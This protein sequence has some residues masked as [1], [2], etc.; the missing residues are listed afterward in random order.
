MTDLYDTKYY[1]RTADSANYNSDGAGI[2][3]AIVTLFKPE[4]VIDAGCGSGRI[5]FNL[6]ELGCKRVHGIEYS[7]AAFEFMN[8]S[9]KDYCHQ[10]DM[11]DKS[12]EVD[13]K[14]DVAICT[15][16]AEHIPPVKSRSLVRNLCKCSDII[17]FSAAPV[18]QGGT[19]HINCRPYEYWISLFKDDGY[20]YD[21]LTT[22]KLK[23]LLKSKSVS[24]FYVNNIMVFGVPQ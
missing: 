20:Y 24:K 11:T 19:G 9:I 17:V 14:Y 1:Q 3:E 22:D 8:A 23:G 5:L 16:V 12:F 10:G 4:S 7:K 6:R 18:G 21:A 15:E 13:N 2:A